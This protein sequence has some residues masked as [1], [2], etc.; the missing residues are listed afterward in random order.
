MIYV[1]GKVPPCPAGLWVHSFSRP[2]FQQEL[3]NFQTLRRWGPSLAASSRAHRAQELVQALI[4]QTCFLPFSSPNC[5]IQA[6][7]RPHSTKD[8]QQQPQHRATQVL[9]ICLSLMIQDSARHTDIPTTEQKYSFLSGAATK[10]GEGRGWMPA[11]RGHPCPH[12]Q[13][14]SFPTSQGASVP[15][16][17]GN[18]PSTGLGL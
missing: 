15:Y 11:R 7:L 6:N 8:K 10:L 17:H 18:Q 13:L 1:R 16:C 5:F 9:K 14:E 2:C 4:K 3:H 12:P